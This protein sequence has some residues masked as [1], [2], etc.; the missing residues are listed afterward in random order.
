METTKNE[1]VTETT[2]K[3]SKAIVTKKDLDLGTLTE[4]VSAAWKQNT[5]ITLIWITQAEFET[6]SKSYLAS[7]DN[8]NV[9][10]KDRPQITVGLK[11]CNQALDAGIA[12]IK[13]Y[14]DAD[15]TS[16]AEAKANYAKFGIVLQGTS[17]KLPKDLD[18]RKQSLKLVLDAIKEFGYDNKPFGTAYFTPLISQYNDLLKNAADTDKNVSTIVGDKNKI[19]EELIKTLNSIV[20]V[21]KGNY[22]DTY[23]N[24]LRAWG[25]QKEKY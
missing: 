18:S 22:P 20:Y 15:A 14:L 11:T 6:K 17:Y 12:K 19:K 8:R 10:Q 16:K 24:V 21:L 9:T 1:N 7:L 3:R 4:N 2:K 5:A 25:F 23:K 13:V